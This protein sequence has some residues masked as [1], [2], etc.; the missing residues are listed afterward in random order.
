MA[1]LE[2]YPIIGVAAVCLLALAGCSS[3]ETNAAPE[4]KR[5]TPLQFDVQIDVNGGRP[6][7]TL[8]TNLPDGTEIGS[9]LKSPGYPPKY[10]AQNGGSVRR[11]RLAV[12]PYSDRGARLPSGRY[13]L[14]V[15]APMTL[16]QPA[17]VRPLLRDDYAAF[18]GPAIKP[19]TGPDQMDGATVETET[20]ITID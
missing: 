1:K 5:A 18:S 2:R 17:H 13:V 3:T 6:R 4:T 7:A 12:G 10:F 9:S 15:T 8:L 16:V 11:G 19:R 20:G 14:S